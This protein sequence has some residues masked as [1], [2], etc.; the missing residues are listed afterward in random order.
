MG[1]LTLR[2]RV[3]IGGLELPLHVFTFVIGFAL[4]AAMFASG[5]AA[6]DC[7]VNTGNPHDYAGVVV[8]SVWHHADG[9]FGG[10]ANNTQ[11]SITTDG[12]ETPGGNIVHL[13][14]DHTTI[15]SRQHSEVFNQYVSGCNGGGYDVVLGYDDNNRNNET[16]DYAG[17]GQGNTT[18]GTVWALDCDI[19]VHPSYFQQFTITGVG[20]PSGAA[21]GGSWSVVKTAPQGGNAA[22]NGSTPHF[23]LVYTEP[24]P[25]PKPPTPPST[26]TMAI[27]C[28]SVSGDVWVADSRWRAGD[29]KNSSYNA[30]AGDSYVIVWD[31]NAGT[32]PIVSSGNIPGK[33]S[34]SNH[35]SGGFNGAGVFGDGTTVQT[36]YIIIYD[37]AGRPALIGPSPS[38]QPPG[39]P[40]TSAGDTGTLDCADDQPTGSMTATCGTVDLSGLNDNNAPGQPVS[41]TVSISSGGAS[42]SFSDSAQG[43]I[44]EG[45]DIYNIGGQPPGANGFHVVVTI[46]DTPAADSGDTSAGNLTLAYDTGPCWA[47]SCSL[48]VNSDVPNGYSGPTGS[49]VAGQRFTV[50]AT[51]SAPSNVYLVSNLGGNPLGFTNNTS[52]NDFPLYSDTGNMPEINTSLA[53]PGNNYASDEPF[54]SD[55]GFG[56]S[57][58]KTL[59]FTA[60]AFTNGKT[61][62]MFV[63]P[64]YYGRFAIG[65]PCTANVNVYQQFNLT[66]GASS[67]PVPSIEAPTS[68]DYKTWVDNNAPVPVGMPPSPP[69][70]VETTVSS[71]YELP[72]AGGKNM[73]AGP[74]NDSGPF[75]PT[76]AGTHDYILN[77][78]APIIAPLHAGDAYYA[79]IDMPYTSAYIGPGGP[80]DLLDPT[81]ATPVIDDFVVQNRPFFKAY[82]TGI[83]AGGSFKTLNASGSGGGEL[84]GWNNNSGTY[85]ASGDYGANAELN[86]LALTQIVGVASGQGRTF[87]G[88]PNGLSF[89]DNP[90]TPDSYSPT[91]GGA[92]D[93]LGSG[94]YLNDQTQPTG[95]DISNAMPAGPIVVPMN[96]QKSI[97][98]TGN[99]Y[100]SGNVL[101]NGSGGIWTLTGANTVPSF[102]LHATG[103]IYID[104]S[105]TELDGLY[106]AQG[107]IFTCATGAGP[108]AS[109]VQ[110]GTCNK[111]LT[112]NGS[113]VASQINLMRTFGSLRDETP[114]PGSAARPL[115]GGERLTMPPSPRPP[116]YVH[117]CLTPAGTTYI[118]H[119]NPKCLPGD[120]WTGDYGSGVPRT[121]YATPCATTSGATM[122]Y[123]YISAAATCPPGTSTNLSGGGP[124]TP[125]VANPCSNAPAGNPNGSNGG[126]NITP[127]CAAEVFQ[128]SPELFLSSPN[129]AP[130]SNGAPQWDAVTSLPPVL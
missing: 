113:F 94:Y 55:V 17:S 36:L 48:S 95:G 112:V 127:T 56:Q 84:A 99:A 22:A 29:P 92:F 118:T 129:V 26:N 23:T 81:G 58:S 97:F 122:R 96:D 9:S 52:G 108:L 4:A 91:L 66:G 50:T 116:Q 2:Q 57:L 126:A 53:S 7:G 119:G 70:P 12:P 104:P 120:S 64:D 105:V 89:A 1:S 128:F 82:N 93:V 30:L 65:G 63:Y 16:S 114:T 10:N 117:I 5:H 45:F 110:F 47:G 43:S 11:V 103:N 27:T 69:N 80:N 3:R 39:Y 87:G 32:G 31:N 74:L 34:N 19:S 33:F 21:G 71:A 68:F 73:I 90:V 101:Y 62:S 107:E 24:N 42:E 77:S 6:A 86:T 59:T 124:A 111:Q 41:F 18:D 130:P 35:Y 78:S 75:A 8:D 61:F 85:P 49:V 72:A 15:I 125:G 76:S 102:V 20:V 83:S 38:V 67:T 60:P 54:G 88:A 100:I 28:S 79:E 115:A 106:I 14:G 123:V 121:F 98:I 40:S 37:S 46:N 13:A 51:M 44:S 25:P 109:T